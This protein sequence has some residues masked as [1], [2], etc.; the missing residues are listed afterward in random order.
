MIRLI[1][2]SITPDEGEIM[3]GRV[4]VPNLALLRHIGY[5]PQ[6]D[7]LYYDISAYDHLNFYGRL[8][9]LSDKERKR[10]AEEL[11]ELVDLSADKNKQIA[12]YSGGM[13]RRLSLAIALMHDPDVLMLDEPTVGIDPVLKRAVWAEFRRFLTMGKAILVSTHVM[14]EAM[15]CNKAALIYEGRLIANDHIEILTEQAEGGNLENL[16]FAANEA[17]RNI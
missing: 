5:M 4:K 12:Y 2:G 15:R 3:V 8:Y 11:L 14:D 16:F 6:G 13:K 17:G 1:T 10:K 9:G 7:A